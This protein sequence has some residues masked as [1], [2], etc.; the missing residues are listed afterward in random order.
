M[1]FS[2]IIGV[3]AALITATAAGMLN[4]HGVEKLMGDEAR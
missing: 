1:R 4:L 3:L 2:Y